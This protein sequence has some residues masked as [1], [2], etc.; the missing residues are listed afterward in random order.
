MEELT[1]LMK[2]WKQLLLLMLV[3]AATMFGDGC[4]TSGNYPTLKQTQT[5]VSWP[6]T[7]YRNAS[8][9]GGVTLGE[10]QQVDAAYAAYEAAFKQ[11]LQEANGNYDAPTPDYLKARA[12][13]L[14]QV[15]SAI[16]YS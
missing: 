8:Y 2:K 13:E 6:M 3:S 4:A 14:I 15:L 1:G 16:P 11:A 9:G 5:N 12:N 7:R 10:K